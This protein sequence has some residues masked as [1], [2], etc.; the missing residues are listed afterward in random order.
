MKQL[1]LI[2]LCCIVC[3][4]GAQTDPSYSFAFHRPQTGK[5]VD[6]AMARQTGYSGSFYTTRIYNDVFALPTGSDE[7][8][9]PN[10]NYYG[11]KK[12][13]SITISERGPAPKFMLDLNN[14][15]QIIKTTRYTDLL[16]EEQ[17]FYDDKG[18]NNMTVKS[19][20]RN[21]I[22]LR[23]DTIRYITQRKVINDSVYDYTTTYTTIYKS[24]AFING[25]NQ[26][27]NANYL[28][29]ELKSDDLTW[30]YAITVKGKKGKKSGT[31]VYQTKKFACDYTPGQF[32]FSAQYIDVPDFKFG[33]H[34]AP[35]Y[36]S[37]KQLEAY[38]PELYLRG[39]PKYSDLPCEQF[40]EPRFTRQSFMCGTG[41]QEMQKYSQLQMMTTYTF[42]QNSNNLQDT[43]FTTRG[44][45][46]DPRY[47]FSYTYFE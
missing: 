5:E 45:T 35:F 47:V 4:A 39:K 12:V 18:T 17:F 36:P 33:Y 15:G 3:K 40:Q 43:C 20:G 44:S 2:I 32:Y 23:L 9:L 28:N 8:T 42:S 25:Q 13:S 10:S 27:Y 30:G 11:E 21:G 26:Y 22:V 19:Y 29:V 6:I 38:I 16:R 37:E 46:K 31:T 7:F 41:M 24:G 34:D 14:K 1:L